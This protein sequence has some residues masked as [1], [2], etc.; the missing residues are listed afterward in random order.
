MFF[1]GEQI[2]AEAQRIIEDDVDNDILLIAAHRGVGKSKLLEDIYGSTAFNKN[3]IVASG[4]TVKVNVS[5][6]RR[7]FAEGIIEYV[8]RHNNSAVRGQLNKLINLSWKVGFKSLV[9]GKIPKDI[10]GTKLCRLSINELKKVYYDLAKDLPLVIVSSSMVLT[11]EEISYL[12]NLDNDPLGEIGARITF[13]VGI[14]ATPQ[15][16]SAISKII[17]N[18]N[19]GV[20]VM[21]LMPVIDKKA[22]ETDLYSM[23]KITLSQNWLEISSRIRFVKELLL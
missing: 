17:N 16:I 5:N 9:S 19:A 11:E 6:L 8:S 12:S 15:S 21:P 2:K 3:L 20:W 14:R 23:R 10:Y 22:N 1:L 13:V 18:R 4:K 7:C